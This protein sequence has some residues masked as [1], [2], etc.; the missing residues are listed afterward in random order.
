[1]LKKIEP[2]IYNFLSLFVPRKVRYK[3]EG[4]CVKCGKCC[5]YMY[6]KD[7]YTERE[8]KI[9]QFIYPAYKRFYIVGKDEENNL[10]FGCKLIDENNLCTDY[11]N[12]LKMCKNYPSKFINFRGELHDNCGF[13]VRPEKS[14]NDYL[15]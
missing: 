13:T 8:F 6:S 5:R 9:M 12:R 7:T 2:F 14:F 4:S 15:K 3:I 11:K 10:I 1:M